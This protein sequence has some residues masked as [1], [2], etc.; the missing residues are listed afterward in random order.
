MNFEAVIGIEIHIELNTSSKMF[1][2]APIKANKQA[3]NNVFPL[4]IAFPGA[5]PTINKQAV[6]HAIR[7]ANVLHMNIDNELWFDRKNYLYSD[8][9]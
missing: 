2:S 5:M 4:D 9:P 8:N 6:I 7:I 3:N 1:S